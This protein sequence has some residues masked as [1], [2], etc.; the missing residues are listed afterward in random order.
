M[1]W[2]V[3]GMTVECIH[4]R[5]TILEKLWNRYHDKKCCDILLQQ[6]TNDIVFFLNVKLPKDL[7]ERIN[8]LDEEI[9]DDCN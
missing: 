8:K 7:E 4:E 9:H 6:L 1:D 2:G 3:Y 5:V